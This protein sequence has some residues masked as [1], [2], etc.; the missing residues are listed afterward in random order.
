MLLKVR[1]DTVYN[2]RIAI[3]LTA[4]L[5]RIVDAS[6][7]YF[8][9]QLITLQSYEGHGADIKDFESASHGQCTSRSLC[10]PM[11]KAPRVVTAVVTAT[12]RET[13][14]STIKTDRAAAAAAATVA[15]TMAENRAALASTPAP[16]VVTKTVT[17][18]LPSNSHQS[19]VYKPVEFYANEDDEDEEEDE[20]KEKEEWPIDCEEEEQETETVT[21]RAMRI[22]HETTTH[23]RTFTHYSE[24]VSTT[25]VITEE[26]ET[27]ISLAFITELNPT[28]IVPLP[29]DVTATIPAPGEEGEAPAPSSTM[30][31]D[32][33]DKVEW[34]EDDEA[35]HHHHK[36]HKHKHNNKDDTY[37]E[38]VSCHWQDDF[39]TTVCVTHINEEFGSVVPW[40]S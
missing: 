39:E 21:R 30:I 31:E 25:T 36:H 35:H 8:G 26:L 10:W 28:T 15:M 5:A 22:V 14:V 13:F 3:Q 23:R 11:V 12:A 1:Y 34:E 27:G 40:E 16:V 20:E 9:G 2:G 18:N 29:I 24:F 37:D 19:N 17:M 7:G 6:T 4:L 32:C 38:V 33:Q